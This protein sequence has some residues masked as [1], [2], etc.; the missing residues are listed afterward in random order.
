MN[1]YNELS[2]LWI[3]RWQ[4]NWEA[5]QNWSITYNANA[6]R[7][8]RVGQGKGKCLWGKTESLGFFSMSSVW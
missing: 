4:C 6:Q 7:F 1:F 3:R 2:G 5:N 8:L